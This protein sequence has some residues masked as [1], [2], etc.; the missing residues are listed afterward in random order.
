MISE[1]DTEIKEG[2][3][4][5]DKTKSEC[6]NANAIRSINAW[7]VKNGSM[8]GEINASFLTNDELLDKP[9]AL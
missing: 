7:S 5:R 2:L 1:S 3:K 9:Q 8:K 6:S 4:E